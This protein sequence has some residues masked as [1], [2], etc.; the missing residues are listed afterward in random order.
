MPYG[1][2]QNARCPRARGGESKVSQDDDS[3]T[4]CDQGNTDVR[5][6]AEV[7]RIP[8]KSTSRKYLYT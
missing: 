3:A 7:G 4:F 5:P 6:P 1:G 2:E 8:R